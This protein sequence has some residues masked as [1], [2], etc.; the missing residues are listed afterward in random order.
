M[1]RK[2]W[3]ILAAGLLLGGAV[4]FC[5]G[6]SPE[7]M[8]LLK[9]HQVQSRIIITGMVL[10]I[11][12]YQLQYNR[13]PVEATP[14]KETVPPRSRGALVDILMAKD[15]KANPLGV[16]FF[17]FPAAKNKR[18]G[19]YKDDQGQS[20]VVDAWGEPFYVLIAAKNQTTIPNPDPR[21][22]KE[23]PVIDKAVI[24]FSAGPDHDPNTWEDN[25]LSWK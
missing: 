20:V 11:Q 3:L 13:P 2:R 8:V 4:G 25:V 22:N 17:D 10:G 18:F 21:D 7:E 14:G 23:H 12:M 5:D 9:A 6:L 1:M 24:M 16:A 15:A 19:Y